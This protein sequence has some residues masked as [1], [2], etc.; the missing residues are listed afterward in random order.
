MKRAKVEFY[1]NIR[2]MWSWRLK[3]PNGK[4]IAVPGEDFSDKA[5]AKRNFGCVVV[6]SAKAR[7]RLMEE[8]GFISND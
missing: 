8:F 3:A 5:K 6:Y 4:I 1:K 2:G 7:T